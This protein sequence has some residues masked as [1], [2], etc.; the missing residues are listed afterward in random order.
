MNRTR[1]LPTRFHMMKRNSILEAL[2][3]GLAVLVT[4]TGAVAG[5]FATSLSNTRPDSRQ[6]ITAVGD[7]VAGLERSRHSRPTDSDLQRTG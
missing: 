3:D 6:P 5:L 4:V 2:T 1:R 7:E